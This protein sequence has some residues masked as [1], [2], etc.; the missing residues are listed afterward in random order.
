M[1]NSFTEGKIYAPLIR[2]ALP[3]LLAVFLQTMYG[4]A[5]MMIVGMFGHAADVSAVSTGSSIMQSITAVI[6]GLS[7]G[8]TVLLGQKIGAG[9]KEEAGIVMGSSIC[10]FVILGLV[11]TGLI[12]IFAAPIARLMQAPEEAFDGTV[13][14][15]RVCATGCVFIVGYNV[16]GSIFR[17]IGDSKMPL[18][19]VLIACVLNILGDLLLVGLF[20]LGVVGAAIATITAQGLSVLICFLII[21][22]K[23]LPFTFR[24][25]CLRLD[26]DSI[27][28]VA[29]LGAPIALQDVLMNLSFLI[30]MAI[31][32]DLGVV[33]SAGVGVAQKLVGFILLVPSAFLQS[34]SA[35][36]A[37][38]IGARRPDRAKKAVMYGI[39]TS[40]GVGVVLAWFSFFHGDLMAGLFAKDANVIAAA[41]EY[42][43]TYAIDALIVSVLFCLMGYFN[44]CG[45]TTFVMI[46]GILG[47]FAVRVPAC[48]LLSRVEPVSLLRIGLSVPLSTITQTLIFV[49][50][51]L[52]LRHKGEEVGKLRLSAEN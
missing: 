15:L 16:L 47:A 25:N 12:E 41:A 33:I 51:L 27:R 6:T 11:F 31:L 22:R 1:K 29:R 2:F 17:G 43:K 35:F 3:V 8:T 4:A 18:I 40:L 5:D 20:G 49:V 21:R 32:N 45:R 34:M 28:M 44:G 38:N 10:V 37:Q 19:S 9:R 39:F 50:Y 30:I 7:M 23:G 14:Y 52:W 48:W 13:T 26:K 42:M 24:R 36:V 46:Q